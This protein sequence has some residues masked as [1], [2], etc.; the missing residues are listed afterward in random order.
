MLS[1]THYEY[2]IL[3]LTPFFALIFG[4]MIARWQKIGL[5]FLAALSMYVFGVYF[6][7]V[8]INNNTSYWYPVTDS[9]VFTVAR[10]IKTNKLDGDTCVFFTPTP[11]ISIFSECPSPS[12][13]L[14]MTNYMHD[15]EGG[16]NNGY[17]EELVQSI[18]TKKPRYLVVSKL[19]E[20]YKY[21]SR[22]QGIFD[23][24]EFVYKEGG[25]EVREFKF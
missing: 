9:D 3:V 18:K 13:F 2:Y 1:G 24:T 11:T 21:D 7:T 23:S 14:N 12:R 17:L 4:V 8:L 6:T 10:Y 19:F 15:I 22:V 16:M 20:Y 5:I 25:L